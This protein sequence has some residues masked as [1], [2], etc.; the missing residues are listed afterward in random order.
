M[1]AA[2]GVH[3]MNQVREDDILYDSL[4]LYHMTGGIVGLGQALLFGT[5]VVIRKRFSASQF[6]KDCIKYEVTVAQYLGETLRYLLAQPESAEE[7]SHKVRLLS[8][9]GLRQEIWQ[10]VIDRFNI[11]QIGEVY[12]S[13]EGNCNVSNIDS[14]VG[15]VGFVPRILYPLMPMTLAKIDMTGEV[16]RDPQTGLIIRCEPGEPGELVGKIIKHH[17]IRD[18]QG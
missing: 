17:P 13:T 3:Y 15:A 12:G 14:K 1:M 10:S 4:P 2:N 9:N 8:G 18:F 7:K 5:S 11:H 16:I 6:W